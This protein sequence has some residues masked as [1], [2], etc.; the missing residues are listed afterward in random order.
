M[1]KLHWPSIRFRLDYKIALLIEVN[2]FSGNRTDSLAKR[3]AFAHCCELPQVSRKCF[4]K[5]TRN[6]KAYGKMFAFIILIMIIGI[7]GCYAN[8]RLMFA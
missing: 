5:Q 4:P 8:I 1:Y 7:G 2:I 6:A 3:Q